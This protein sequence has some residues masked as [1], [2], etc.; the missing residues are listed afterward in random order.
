VLA[1]RVLAQEHRIYPEALAAL[2]KIHL[3]GQAAKP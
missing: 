1:A 3:P 2:A